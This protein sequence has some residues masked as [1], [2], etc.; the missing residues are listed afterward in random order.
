MGLLKKRRDENLLLLLFGL[1]LKRDWNCMKEEGLK[2]VEMKWE[3]KKRD[4]TWLLDK[5]GKGG[6]RE[7]RIGSIDVRTQ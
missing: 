4:K 3:K 7:L 1:G 2:A 5:L 6:R